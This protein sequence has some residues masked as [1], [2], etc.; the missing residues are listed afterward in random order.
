MC[1]MGRSIDNALIYPLGVLENPTQM[2]ETK[3]AKNFE[4]RPE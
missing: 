3:N 4:V 1:L 2:L